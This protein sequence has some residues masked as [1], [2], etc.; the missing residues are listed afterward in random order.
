MESS[1]PAAF[2]PNPY[3]IGVPLTADTG[4]YGRSDVFQFIG[5]MLDSGQ[6]RVIV[7][8]GQRRVGKTSI[9]H[10]A[11]RQLQDSDNLL[12]VYFDLQGKGRLSIGQVLLQIARELAR[13]LSINAPPETMVDEDGRFFAE[14]VLPTVY[15]H[16][17]SNRRLLL[18][19]DEFDVLGD[20]IQL[21]VT[22]EEAPVTA[23]ETLCP[24]LRDLI[25]QHERIAF[26]FVVGRR[27]DELPSHYSVIL[28]QAAYRKIGLLREADARELILQPS[29]G[30]VEFQPE[31]IAHILRLGAGHPYFTQ[32]MC[33]EA[34]NFLRAENRRELSGKD[35][36][37]LL[38]K[39]LETGHCALDWF[40][41]GLPAAERLILSAIASV[42]DENGMAAKTAVQQ[43]LEKHRL[44]LTGL[45]LTE[46]PE[47]LVE[48]EILQRQD[49]D[50]Y[51]FTVDLI[52]R[53]MQQTHPLE[54]ARRDVNFISKRAA[55]L[56][57]LAREAH[58]AGDYLDAYNIYRRV[59]TSNPNHSGAQLGLAYALY[60]LDD[61]NGA[62][63]AFERAYAIDDVAAHDGL[64]N[65]LIELGKR[66][67][68]RQEYKNAKE[69]YQRALA[70]TPQNNE[71]QNHLDYISNK[72]TD[73]YLVLYEI[74]TA[75]TRLFLE[76]L[77]LYGKI[78]SDASVKY[79]KYLI[80]SLHNAKY[81]EDGS[82]AV[83]DQENKHASKP[84]APIYNYDAIACN[85]LTLFSPHK[86]TNLT[87]KLT[88]NISH[89]TR[90]LISGPNDYAKMALFR[91]ICQKWDFMEGEI[92]T[93]GKDLAFIPEDIEIPSSSLREALVNKENNNNISDDKIL[94]VMRELQITYI[95]RFAGGL[96]NSNNW[97][98]ILP[99]Q[100]R[101]RIAIAKAILNSQRFLFAEQ[102]SRCFHQEEIA[103]IFKT[104]SK[105]NIT[106]INTG[107]H[108]IRD[109]DD[110][111][112]Y[113]DAILELM[114]DG[115]WIWSHVRDGR[116]NIDDP[117]IISKN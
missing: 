36:L 87:K 90:L 40:W 29:H 26:I 3:V 70:L 43:G 41:E 91:A 86:L 44:V 7:L 38:D 25:L 109:Y 81:N 9:L 27:I 85:D 37:A 94:D 112:R 82:S 72:T 24:Y 88:I 84:V 55:R 2:P 56:Y 18:L 95:I 74:L 103:D 4:F 75:T 83:T 10:Q 33:F 21:A 57:E 39:A 98:N 61:L 68:N 11:M 45:E 35:L 77:L 28:K 114:M 105:N 53:W 50:A 1:S 32:L 54:T 62:L 111:L 101:V 79:I 80:N 13:T 42:S 99:L 71:L 59:L 52:R 113:Y 63:K 89:G 107:V 64:I 73:Y 6:Q 17:G 67:E 58:I 16:L 116:I 14:Q 49:G 78:V 30:V 102:L 12:P 23:C 19:F 108:G 100:A 34:Y 22:S 46:A 92:A 69:L 48:W 51:R 97:Q 76:K 66:H 115:Y 117:P 96:D 106:Y 31:A 93:P 5:D 110:K 8:Y 15:E 65:A 60:S 47:R 20:D 104:L